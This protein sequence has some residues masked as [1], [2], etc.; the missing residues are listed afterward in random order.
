MGE[1]ML[2]VI[3]MWIIT[4]L[5]VF[6]GCKGNS[7]IE[8]PTDVPTNINNNGNNGSNDNGSNGSNNNKQQGLRLSMGLQHATD[9]FDV[10]SLTLSNCGAGQLYSLSDTED[11]VRVASVLTISDQQRPIIFIVDATAGCELQ[12]DG[13]TYAAVQASTTNVAAGVASVIFNNSRVAANLIAKPN[14]SD[15]ARL[16]VSG[17]SGDD[18]HKIET[19]DWGGRDNSHQDVQWDSKTHQNNR[20]LF[21]IEDGGGKR[22]W[23]AATAPFHSDTDGV[24]PGAGIS[25]EGVG[26]QNSAQVQLVE[27]CGLAMFHAY[28]DKNTQQNAVLLLNKDSAVEI[29][30]TDSSSGRIMIIAA[31]TPSSMSCKPDFIINGIEFTSFIKEAN[32]PTPDTP[33]V[34]AT[35]KSNGQIKITIPKKP[36]KFGD[37][38]QLHY[39]GEGRSG[40]NKFQ[41]WFAIFQPSWDN[42]YDTS[43]YAVGTVNKVL[44]KTQYHHSG[45][46]YLKWFYTENQ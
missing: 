23:H 5:L 25:I 18:W 1:M 40:S 7:E 22:W 34:A 38:L 9:D 36:N 42:S 46:I 32:P 12:I 8:A 24:K 39:Y 33:A 26:G 15:S 3:K 27:N 10:G 29:P 31:G 2:R 17:N 20:V 28:I 19:L 45:A 37:L 44:F 21:T 16:Y 4:I 43:T 11:P 30:H 35:K 6:S 41:Q 13:K 14:N